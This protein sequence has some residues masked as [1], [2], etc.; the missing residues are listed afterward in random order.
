MGTVSKTQHIKS[1][2]TRSK[3]KPVQSK[4]KTATVRKKSIKRSVQPPKALTKKSQ[5]IEKTPTPKK[6]T[7]KVKKTTK[8]PKK[9]TKVRKKTTKVAKT[10]TTSI[11]KVKKASIAPKKPVILRDTPDVEKTSKIRSRAVEIY[12]DIAKKE[13]GVIISDL[14]KGTETSKPSTQ[15]SAEF[16]ILDFIIKCGQTSEMSVTNWMLKQNYPV[17]TIKNSFNKLKSVN[18]VNLV[19]DGTQDYCAEIE[20]ITELEEYIKSRE[21]KKEI[22]KK[23]RKRKSTKK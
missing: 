13:S 17:E 19:D 14:P 6:K 20:D 7:S 1:R 11:K 21:K 22:S 16:A 23:G 15:E 12:L 3:K 8:V 9:P 18:L 10:P 5:T 2:A 4:K